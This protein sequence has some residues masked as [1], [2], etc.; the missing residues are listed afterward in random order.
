MAADGITPALLDRAVH[1]RG[2]Y[3]RGTPIRNYDP[4]FI[5]RMVAVWDQWRD[6][7]DKLPPEQPAPDPTADRLGLVM[8]DE[9]GDLPF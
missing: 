9:D 6:F 5:A 2:C 7:I 8:V 3:P 1:A 4:R